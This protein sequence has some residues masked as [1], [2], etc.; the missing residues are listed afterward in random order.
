[1]RMYIECVKCSVTCRSTSR[2]HTLAS[3]TD[4]RAGILVPLT[5]LGTALRFEPQGVAVAPLTN[6]SSTLSVD[7]L[8]IGY[9]MSADV[10][11]ASVEVFVSG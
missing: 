7:D 3:L 2:A 8:R 11:D 9:H 10:V 6:Q 4:H 1:M 5:P